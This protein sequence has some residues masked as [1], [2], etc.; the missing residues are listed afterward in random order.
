MARMNT[1]NFVQSVTPGLRKT[2]FST[3]TEIP[4][5]FRQVFNVIGSNPGG[6][7]GRH[8]FEDLQVASFGTAAYKA[9]GDAIT[10]DTFTEGNLV[11]YTPSVYATGARVTME[12]KAD[13]LTGTMTKIAT[14]L[15]WSV[16]HQMEVQAFRI[17]N[18]GF[19]TTGGTG[20]TA[21]GYDTLALFSTAHTLLGGG[22]DANRAATD[23][24]LGITSLEDAITTF[25]ETLNESGM[26]TPKRASVLIHGP[27]LKFIAKE[28]LDSELKPYTGNNEVNPLGG[29]GISRMM[30]NYLTDSDSWFLLGAKSQLDLNVWIRQEPSFET[31]DD[32]DTKDMKMSALTRIA[33]GHGDWRGTFG[34]QGA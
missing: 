7:A 13:D 14:E 16:Y 28:L 3:L 33:A 17:L 24:D 34:S 29:E 22:T 5:Q 15:A 23:Q 27:A 32:F 20:F 19:S 31:G 8:F 26:P 10:Y 18:S 30:V 9:E 25:D 21:A 4:K 1:A 6:S 12:M 2:F 11:R